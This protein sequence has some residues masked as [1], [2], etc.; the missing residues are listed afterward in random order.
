MFLPIELPVRSAAIAE[1]LADEIRNRVIKEFTEKL[2][3]ST[4]DDAVKAE[5][6]AKIVNLAVGGDWYHQIE[7][8]RA[9][10]KPF[11][12][13]LLEEPETRAEMRAAVVKSL[14]AYVARDLDQWVKARVNEML[15]EEI[16][17][18]VVVEIAA[19]LKADKQKRAKR[20]K[21]A[22][23]RLSPPH[24]SRR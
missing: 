10:M 9:G 6:R 12:D 18:A 16:R 11:I 8:L 15:K 21:P 17:A 7:P 2:S 24:A 5:L 20:A 1:L 14:R 23:R 4:I 22:K 19:A 13:A 3:L